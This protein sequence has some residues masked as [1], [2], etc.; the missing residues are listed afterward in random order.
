MKNRRSCLKICMGKAA[1][2]SEESSEV[3]A[4]NVEET[5]LT[6]STWTHCPSASRSKRSPPRNLLIR[7]KTVHLIFFLKMTRI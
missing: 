5:S 3:I 7:N 2:S 1:A 6:S 4:A